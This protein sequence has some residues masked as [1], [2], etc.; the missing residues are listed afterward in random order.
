MLADPLEVRLVTVEV[1]AI[2]LPFDRADTEGSFLLVD[3][4]AIN[5]DGGA[6]GIH[7]W[8]L[9]VP[10][11]RIFDLKFRGH[12]SRFSSG[13]GFA[14]GGLRGGDFATADDFF[15]NDRRDRLRGVIENRGIDNDLGFRLRNLRSLN[16]DA[17]VI[18]VDGVRLGEPDV[19]V[20]ATT[21]IP[22]RRVGRVI[23]ADGDEV[24]FTN[25]EGKGVMSTRKEP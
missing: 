10:Q 15:R 5:G 24:L 2:G 22:T 9:G 12:R 11:S 23:D 20:N 7:V 18:D 13:D 8:G 16:E 25:L 14:V 3:L 6:H 17:P 19:A 4:L 1:E 21:W